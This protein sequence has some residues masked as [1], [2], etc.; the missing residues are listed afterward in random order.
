VKDELY[1]LKTIIYDF[2][3]E[4]NGLL[5]KDLTIGNKTSLLLIESIA[6]RMRKGK[7]RRIAA[8]RKACGRMI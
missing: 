3:K 1:S 2:G 7:N 6:W 4:R 5:G 8:R